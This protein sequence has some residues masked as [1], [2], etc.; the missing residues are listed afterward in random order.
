MDAKAA[1]AQADK[2]GGKGGGD[3]PKGR[4]GVTMSR[5]EGKVALLTV[6]GAVP[7]DSNVMDF[8]GCVEQRAVDIIS[9]YLRSKPLDHGAL[10]GSASPTPGPASPMHYPSDT[11]VS[12]EALD[13][14][15]FLLEAGDN[16]VMVDLSSFRNRLAN[17]LGLSRK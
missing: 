3:A 9:E 1:Q 6:Q 12:F 4:K 8:M 5:P 11:N 10:P 2:K 17:K 7:T 16:E 15:D 14:D 13:D